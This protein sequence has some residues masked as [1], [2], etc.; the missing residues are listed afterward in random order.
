MNDSLIRDIGRSYIV[1]S[2]LP[3]SF[4][5]LLAVV[6]FQGFLPPFRNITTEYNQNTNEQTIVI[7]SSLLVLATIM[8]VAFAL[9]SSVDFIFKVYEGYYLPF[10]IAIPLKYFHY[11]WHKH[12]LKLLEDYETHVKRI[13]KIKN[14]K[15]K[16]L[17]WEKLARSQRDVEA[18]LRE[19]EI[20]APLNYDNWQSYLPTRLG[21]IILASELYSLEKYRMDGPT[22]FPR[23]SLL[24][25]PEFVS[26]FEEKNNQV[27]FLLNSS[28]LAFLE[29]IIAI[30]IGAWGLFSK[31]TL[32]GFL[33]ISAQNLLFIGAAFLITSY[34][35]YSISINAVKEYSLFVRSSF[36]LYR[37]RLLKELNL[38]IP[39]SLSEEQ[40]VWKALS[41]FVVAG[42]RLGKKNFYYDLDSQSFSNQKKKN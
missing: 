18:L 17:E 40:Q 3:A 39:T 24:F 14:K 31:S 12:K 22:L 21:N 9:Y 33:I 38:P 42:E 28:F 36:D 25:P 13:E 19:R 1:S 16:R 32:S 8:W 11:R 5:V 6:I 35:I 23:M 20:L 15:E 29:G 26:A 27:I 10:F 4:F 2:L 30:F 7:S 41:Q 34:V 37:F